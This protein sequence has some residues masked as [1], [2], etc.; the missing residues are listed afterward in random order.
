MAIKGVGSYA[1]ASLLMLLS[2]Y[3]YVPVDSWARH[4]VSVE[5]HDG[6]PVGAAEVE[7]AFQR[8]GRWKGLAYW[9][10]SWHDV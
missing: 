5:W 1:A 9:F 6:A 2:R 7:A 4:R 3:D 10:W 8:W